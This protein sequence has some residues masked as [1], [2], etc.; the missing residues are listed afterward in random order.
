MSW[1]RSFFNEVNNLALDMYL[2]HIFKAQETNYYLLL[3]P[4][5]NTRYLPNT[6]LTLWKQIWWIEP[7]FCTINCNSNHCMW[8]WDHKTMYRPHNLTK[9]IY[10]D[11]KIDW[12]K[13]W[14]WHFKL[15]PFKI[16]HNP[17]K[18]WPVFLKMH[19]NKDRNT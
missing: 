4:Y 13:Y 17:S 19:K 12:K 18:I 6:Y 9:A 7:Y 11:D 14:A 15:V 2:S 3:F 16:G 5:Y 10:H 1:Q 8:P